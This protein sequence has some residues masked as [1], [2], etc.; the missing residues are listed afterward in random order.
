MKSAQYISNA[1]PAYIESLYNDFK[2]NPNS[3][4]IEFKKF[5]EGFD[6]AINTGKTNNGATTG[7]FNIKELQVYQLIEAYRERGHL[8]AQ[9]NPIRPRKD[10]KPHLD[11]KY[12]GLTDADL[13]NTFQIGNEIGLKNG[14]LKQI[15]AQLKKVYSADIGFEYDYITDI[16]VRD[17]LRQ[18]I[19]HRFNTHFSIDKKK[20]ILQ[21]LNETVVLEQFLGTK[22]LG[23]KRFSLEGGESTIPALD[24]IINKSAD[25]GVQEVIIGMAH[26]GRLNVLA[27]IMG[28]TYDYIFAEF[29]GNT[30]ED[31][32]MGDG[33]VKYHLGF[34]SLLETPTNKKVHLKLT[35]N[36]SHLEA[37]D[38]VV[39]GFA[40]A[41]ADV[42]YN[43][44]YDQ[45]LPILIHGDA[46]IAGQGIVYEVAQMSKLPGYYT[47]G[48]IHFIINNQIGFTTDF[49]DARSSHY[50]TSVASVVM[51]PVIHVNGDQVEAV[52]FAVELAAEFRQKF[53]RDIYVDMVCYRK[54]GHNEGDDPK[55]TQP[56]LYNLIDN[57]PNPRDIYMNHLDKK[58]QVE[59]AL[60]KKLDVEFRKELQARLENIK[61]NHLPYKYQKPEQEWR[62]LK[63]K[64]TPEDF[65]VSP[66]TG[67][68]K[69]TALQI[70]KSLIT[71]PDGFSILKKVQRLLNKNEKL[72][73]KNETLDWAGAE[74]LAY[75]SL[76]KEG[77]DIR[78][79]GQDIKRGTFSHRHSVL[80]D[81]KTQAPHYRL[82]YVDEKQGLFRIY[83]SLLSEFAVLGFEFGYS[84]ASPNS[85]VIW[86]AQ[87]GDFANGA[88]TIIDQFIMSSESKWRRNSGL[89]MLLPHGYEGQGPEHSSARLE[90]FLQSSAEYN[91]TVANIT[92]PA[93]FFH[94]LRRQL[95]RNFRK[96]LIVM[97]PKSLLRH[98]KCISSIDDVA[99]NTN[100][101]EVF[102]DKNTLAATKVT[103]VLACSGKIYYDLL[104][105]KEEHKRTDTAIV[106]IEQLY[107]LP[108]KQIDKLIV[109]Y[110]NATFAWV[111]EEPSNMG[112]WQYI[113]SCYR[114][115]DL[116][117]IGRKSSASPATGFKKIHIIE[118]NDIIE[119][120]F[121]FSSKRASN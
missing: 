25:L 93:N 45:I 68:T 74:L 17:W 59:A 120:A 78:M 56:V 96:P 6:F 61:Q 49:D 86:E 27:N 18:K 9:T 91:V 117:L 69:K 99:P 64:A 85:M 92:T 4:D 60:A 54:H 104:A 1:H 77:I 105:Y 73:V 119:K 63:S 94:L 42:V 8:I 29:E 5:F 19:E 67:I 38:P 80:V 23:E 71:L 37:V 76:L 14:T 83:N 34:S 10:R 84:L 107:P 102:D 15:L 21:K 7:A 44:D 32:T 88:Q 22:Y 98:A 57:H 47:G 2:E 16:E 75:G 97:S 12:Y 39:Q 112:A 50:C 66:K 20:R 58:G 41:K 121:N 89:V 53:N 79:S 62:K 24:A 35:P 11:L 95:A 72:W 103:R 46:A 101:K 100:F 43:R 52:V 51:A 55:F 36:P 13:D 108:Y 40:R 115:A 48:T 118:Q 110:K 106:R 116:T 87:F 109:K 26:R 31:N 33:D 70:L 81:E 28:K 114:N 65:E 30:P 113:L 111:Q 90:R 3:V 82:N